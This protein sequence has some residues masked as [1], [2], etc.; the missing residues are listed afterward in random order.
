MIDALGAKVASGRCDVG[1]IGAAQMD[2]F[3]NVNTT[4]MW[5]DPENPCYVPPKTRL[6][7]SGGAPE[8]TS[9]CKRYII[10]AAHEKKRFVDK[11][12]YITSPGFLTGGNAREKYNFPGS[13]PAMIVTTLC[14]MRPDP[15]TKEFML[16]RISSIY[17]HRRGQ[18]QYGLGPEGFPGSEGH[19]GTH[20]A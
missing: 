9:G 8:I 19:T 6:A 17:H 20:A 11:V 12:D 13:G 16:T 3:G 7:G 18:G 14:I 1:I 2:K 5:E 10:M 4:G 15:L